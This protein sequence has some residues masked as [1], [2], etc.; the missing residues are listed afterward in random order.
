[1]EG[2]STTVHQSLSV[3]VRRH[4]ALTVD[5]LG[6]PQMAPSGHRNGTVVRTLPMPTLTSAGASHEPRPRRASRPSARTQR[7]GSCAAQTSRHSTQRWSV[8]RADC[9]RQ[10]MN[11]VWAAV[12]RARRLTERGCVPSRE[13]SSRCRSR[14]PA[15]TRSVLPPA[16]GTKTLRQ[17]RLAGSASGAVRVPGMTCR[18]T[19]RLCRSSPR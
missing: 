6:P 17:W 8:R 11:R 10:I 1:M 12:A 4:V 18:P 13:R 5:R 19:R 15:T 7:T 3:Q 14:P 2:G 16:R 9:P